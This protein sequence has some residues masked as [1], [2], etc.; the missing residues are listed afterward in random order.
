[1]ILEPSKVKAVDFDGTL[2]EHVSKEGQHFEYDPAK[3]GDPVEVM[4]KRVRKWL[5]EGREVVIFTARVHPSGGTEN[6]DK[7]TGAIQEFCLN[8]FGRVLEI[9]C[10]KSPSFEE[11]WDDRVVRV[12]RNTGLVSSQKDVEDPLLDADSIGDFFG[13]V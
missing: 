13:N 4:V 3:V 6:V 9:T 1:M 5:S 12:D 11:I 2:A 7:A 10:M 8:H